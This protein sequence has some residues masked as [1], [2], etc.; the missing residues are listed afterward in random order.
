[1]GIE[2]SMR[3]AAAFLLLSLAALPCK[4][5]APSD[6]AGRILAAHNAERTALNLPPLVWSETLAAHAAVWANKL[7]QTGRPQ[8]SPKNERVGEGENLWMGSAGGFTPEEMVGAWAQE[9]QFFRNGIFPDV[10]T[11]GEGHVVGHY[12]QMIWKD[13]SQLGCAVASGGGADVLVFRYSPAGNLIGER[14]Y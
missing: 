8:H 10:S 11:L 4:A 14:P 3:S 12:T 13:T 5:A 2:A 6:F 7:A 1:M 9:K